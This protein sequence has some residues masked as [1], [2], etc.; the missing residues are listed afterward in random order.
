[1]TTGGKNHAELT[2][3]D[4]EAI[5]QMLLA[6]GA[7]LSGFLDSHPPPSSK[8]R[9][10]KIS[11]LIKSRKNVAEILLF[12]DPA[13]DGLYHAKE[14]NKKLANLI[15]VGKTSKDGS[16][17]YLDDSSM[18]KALK[19]LVDENLLLRTT[20]K[21]ALKKIR[22][23]QGEQRYRE[24]KKRYARGG[25]ISVYEPFPDV[26]RLRKI[27]SKPLVAKTFHSILRKYRPFQEYT[28]VLSSYILYMMRNSE[29]E[30]N[31]LFQGFQGFHNGVQVDRYS[32]EHFRKRLSSLDDRQLELVKEKLST[33]ILENTLVLHHVIYRLYKLPE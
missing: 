14:L 27:M 3:E 21:E 32:G 18:S 5:N 13:A 2:N 26:A 31:E 22:R 16:R 20:G 10:K 23:L 4:R 25:F 9:F 24:H 1:M 30:M 12:L 11:K 19:A 6:C 15:G 17:R 29:E 7:E 8:E 33:L 28:K